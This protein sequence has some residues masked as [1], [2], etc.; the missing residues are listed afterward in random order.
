MREYSGGGDEMEIIEEKI[1]KMEKELEEGLEKLF[2]EIIENNKVN[3]ELIRKS[4]P[5]TRGKYIVIVKFKGK[6]IEEEELWINIE[7][8]F[9]KDVAIVTIDKNKTTIPVEG[10]IDSLKEVIKKFIENNERKDT[11]LTKVE[12]KTRKILEMLN[13]K[14]KSLNCFERDAITYGVLVEIEQAEGTLTL[15]YDYQLQLAGIEYSNYGNPE[16]VLNVLKILAQ[17]IA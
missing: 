8:N 4:S 10:V 12:E 13:I 16:D 17:H 11:I 6:W 2:K 1:E 9:S 7:A 14:Y 5:P 15:Y 3:I